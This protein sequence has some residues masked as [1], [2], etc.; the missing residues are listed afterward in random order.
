MATIPAVSRHR[1]LLM[2]Y[3]VTPWVLGL[4]LQLRRS[5]VIEEKLPEDIAGWIRKFLCTKGWIGT[6]SPSGRAILTLHII[7]KGPK[8][9]MKSPCKANDY[10]DPKFV[11]SSKAR[12]HDCRQACRSLGFLLLP[13]RTCCRCQRLATASAVLDESG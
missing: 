2:N 10:K 6:E 3:R 1:I 4:H 7:S 13:H 8:M 12:C 5:R 11:F 9:N